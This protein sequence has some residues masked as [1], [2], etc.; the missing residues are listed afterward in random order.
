MLIFS[1]VCSAEHAD[2]SLYQCSPELHPHTVYLSALLCVQ[3][4][5]GLLSVSALIIT[6][7]V[8]SKCVCIAS[9]HN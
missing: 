4:F 5:I 2:F 7:C 1:V 6:P 3:L 9:A 8:L